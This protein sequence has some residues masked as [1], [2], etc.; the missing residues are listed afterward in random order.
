MK[1]E[2]VSKIGKLGGPIL[3]KLSDAVGKAAERPSRAGGDKARELG[4]RIQGRAAHRAARGGGF[5]MQLLGGR[6]LPTRRAEAQMI[7]RGNEWNTRENE[8]AAG[9]ARRMHDSAYREGGVVAGKA[10]LV[11]AVGRRGR[12]AEQAVIQLLGSNSWIEFQNSVIQ[13]GRDQGKRVTEVAAWQNVLSEPGNN[14]LWAEVARRRPDLTPDVQ[15]SAERALGYRFDE[16][17][18]SQRMLLD[19]L[20]RLCSAEAIRR[21]DAT[22]L[23]GLHE[24]IFSEVG[25]LN[26]LALSHQLFTTLRNIKNTGGTVGRDALG[27]LLGPRALAIDTALAPIGES[28]S[29]I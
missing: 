9:R 7:Q 26:D 29:S 15:Q 4:E 3:G 27:S 11:E 14:Q 22:M 18:G 28:Y 10:A 24:G 21:F 6:I 16:V 25:R 20:S 23:P 8:L 1:P 5:L 19:N 17:P 12:D 2:K 13:R